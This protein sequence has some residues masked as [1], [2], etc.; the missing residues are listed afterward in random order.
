MLYIAVLVTA[1]LLI[2]G[3][4]RVRMGHPSPLILVLSST[5]QKHMAFVRK[6]IRNFKC[7]VVLA[8][9]LVR[10]RRCSGGHH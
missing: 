3:S 8:K 7:Y 9:S 6:G 1:T 2:V 5:L 4:H 10:K